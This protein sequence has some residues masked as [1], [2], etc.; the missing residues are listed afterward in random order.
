MAID[1]AEKRKSLV[2]VGFYP[3][4]PGVTPN[5]SP[6]QEWRQEAGYGYPGILAA[7]AQT[8]KQAGLAHLGLPRVPPRFPLTPLP[9]DYDDVH[10]RDLPGVRPRSVTPNRG[11]GRSRG[12]PDHHHGAPPRN[13]IGDSIDESR[14]RRGW[15]ALANTDILNRWLDGLLDV[16]GLGTGTYD[17][18]LA[19]YTLDVSADLDD[20]GDVSGGSGPFL[21]FSGGTWGGHTLVE[22][23]ISDL[24]HTDTNAIHD[25]VA[26]EISGVT[27]KTT[28]VSADLLIIE[29][30]AAS[31]V[32]KKV[33]VGNLP[34]SGTTSPLTTKGDIWVY[35]TDDDRLPIGSDGQVLVADSTQAL[36]LKYEDP[37]AVQFS[38]N[39]IVDKGSVGATTTL[40]FTAGTWQKLT[41]TEDLTISFTDPNTGT[42]EWATVKV[43]VTDDGL[44]M[45][46]WALTWPSNV[47]TE[48]GMA[49]PDPA[50]GE[51]NIYLFDFDGTNYYLLDT[52]VTM[53]AI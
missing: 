22:S 19:T 3:A 11:G 42:D 26:N 34:S 31:G 6:D 28:P 43:Q 53:Q 24:D 44:D 39:G 30:S 23:D 1:S 12:L 41:T 15:D 14:E 25:N 47:Y 21:K 5:A 27:E 46:G 49:L 36:G 18:D 8:V 38:G 20:L 48:S 9:G 51:S 16:T 33:Q 7:E 29:D 2:A 17:S 40:D 35:G 37:D 32:K 4:G 52:K 45:A 50:S 10:G 13:R